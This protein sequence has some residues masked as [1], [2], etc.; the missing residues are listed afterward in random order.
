MN[1]LPRLS[2]PR[3]FFSCIAAVLF[4]AGATMHGATA[5][6]SERAD[7][8]DS[9]SLWLDTD[10]RPIDAHGGGI[11]RHDGAYYWYGEMKRGETE[12]PACNASWGGTRVP[13]AGVSCYASTDLVHWRHLGNVLPV[14]AGVPE[15]QPDRV[16]ERPKVIFNRA[17]QT[18][19]MWMH[20]D[21]MDYH[22]ART[23]IAVAKS[24]AG[25]FHFVR[26]FRPD[27]GVLPDDMPGAT[28]EEFRAAR[29]AGAAALDAW[30]ARH[31]EWRIWARD[32]A[33]GQMARDMALFV[34][35]DGAAYQFYAS[36]E[37]RVM[38]VSRLSD[39][40]LGHAGRY[41]RIT[42]DS[43]EAPA[44]FKWRGRYY[45]FSSGC[46]G[47]DPNPTHLHSAPNLLGEW[48]DRGPAFAEKSS[49]AEVSYLSQ[50]TF[51]LPLEGGALLYLADRWNKDDLAQSRY[52]WLP[53]E[54]AGETPKLR[55]RQTWTLA[56]PQ[57]R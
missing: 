53:V 47:W 51:V 27:A 17:T 15:L 7:T 6:S 33:G 18:F 44:P 21:S 19:V 57:R 40:Y 30:G 56:A 26:S 28:R 35:D 2:R 38:H 32:F 29:A 13:F 10:G 55:W 37:N 9:G 5:A 54:T 36:E 1:F 46:T 48:T 14:T 41:R 34:D 23:G 31:D 43:R 52:V 20:V 25:P 50:T 45:L 12:L 39:D 24:P 8:I 42:F 4:G 22:E 16:I 49:A 11:L 3:R